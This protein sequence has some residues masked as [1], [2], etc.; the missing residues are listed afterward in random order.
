MI[1]KG[2]QR[3]GGQQ[4]AT[5]LLNEYANDRVEVVEVRGAVA[6]DLH[7]AFAEWFAES[8]ATKCRKYLY[9]LSIN[10]DHRQG[11]FAREKYFDFIARAERSLGFTH[12]PRAVVFHVKEGREHCH[13]AW[14]RIDVEKMKAV[15]NGNDYYELDAVTREFA[16][17]HGITLPDGMQKEPGKKRSRNKEKV[18]N[19]DDKQKQERTGISK[20]ERRRIVTEAWRE[21]EDGLG[22]IRALEQRGYYLARGKSAPYVVVDRY[23]E[24][25]SLPRQIEGADTADVRKRLAA[26]DPGKLPDAARAQEFVRQQNEEKLRQTTEADRQNEGRI[27]AERKRAGLEAT[28]RHRREEL[29]KKQ[30]ILLARHGQEARALRQIQRDQAAGILTDRQRHS[31]GLV[32]FLSRITG[33]QAMVDMRNRKTDLLR[34]RENRAQTNALR[35]RHARER[36]DFSRHEHALTRVEKRELRSLRTEIRR[37]FLRAIAAPTREQRTAQNL[38]ALRENISD[39]TAPPVKQPQR[40]NDSLADKFRKRAESEQQ[41]WQRTADE[42]RENAADITK[43]P[44]PQKQQEPDRETLR[45]A[46]RRR[47]ADKRRDRD[48]DGGREKHHHRP[49]PDPFRFPAR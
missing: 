24:I 31:T 38:R 45:D 29:A 10:P 18:E 49:A 14:S 46:F 8:K 47:A 16:R 32:A 17:D 26:Y 20:A 1:P 37:D 12:Q 36:E 34:A 19:Y 3:A 13:V 27:L 4:L 6:Q 9:S 15:H 39:I 2:S 11:N 42:I 35:R 7:G 43:P 25:H 33:I 40:T 22:L 21:S 23:G 41:A 5:H 48:R 28:H 44:A 30:E